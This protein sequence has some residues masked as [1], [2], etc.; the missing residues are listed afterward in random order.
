MPNSNI[1]KKLLNIGLTKIHE[2]VMFTDEP[3]LP[4]FICKPN[5]SAQ[6]K[7][8][9]NDVYGQGSSHDEEMAKIK[10]IGEYFERLCIYNPYKSK[11]INSKYEQN[12]QIDPKLF[13]CYSEEQFKNK[14]LYLDM[15][16]KSKFDWCSVYDVNNKTDILIPAQL[17]YLHSNFNDNLLIRREQIT[18]GAAFGKKDNNNMAFKFGFL[19]AVERDAYITS[20][21]TKRKIPEIQNF[22]GKIEKIL[23]YL[24]RYR[25]KS[26]VFDITTDLNI[27]TFMTITIDETGIGPA[28]DIG[29]SSGYNHMNAIYH[30]I[31]ESIQAR[32]ISR[33]LKETGLR[34][35][36]NN[37]IK[38]MQD[39]YYYW[40]D[41]NKINDLDFWLKNNEK[42]TY[43][44][45]PTYSK[46]FQETK[47]IFS[48]KNYH[49]YIAD[50]SIDEIKHAGF[51]ALK[52]IIPELHPLY[53]DEDAKSLFSIHAGNI[54]DD[55]SLKPHPFV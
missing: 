33:F 54:F 11:L 2:S 12:N 18:T 30:S 40:Y 27:P 14:T 31:K 4:T 49:I 1:L 52:I 51:E 50:I 47:A 25:L 34:S 5:D 37:T 8:I 36:T 7:F 45:I 53:L 13:V 21:L 48:E 46:S 39:R 38:T 22:P 10:S 28:V 20:Y 23:E 3:K 44:R 41:L 29:T 15:L 24:K 9:C 6:K 26:H 55:L 16:N 35:V 17:I 42:I 32:R 19:E 43:D